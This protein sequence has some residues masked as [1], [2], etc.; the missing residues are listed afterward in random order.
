MIRWG[1]IGAGNIAHR[2]MQGMSYETDAA[3]TAVS[4]RTE[5][6]ARRFADEY[7][8]E[9]AYGGF[10]KIV[11]DP[12][13]DAVY[14][15]VPHRYHKEWVLKC[16]RAGKAVLCEKP[17]GMNADEVR[18][19]IHCAGENNVLFMEAMKTR[20][21]PLYAEIWKTICEGTIGEIA[22]VKASLC[23]LMDFEHAERKTYHTDPIGGGCLLDE[24]VYCASWIEAFL[25]KEPH[26][27]RLHAL[28]KDGVDYY[29]D[30]FLSDGEI[31]A[32]LECAFD[33]EMDRYCIISGT[34]GKI[35]IHDLHRPQKAE[36][37]GA[38]ENAYTITR[39]Y[40]HD[41]FYGEIHHFD[42]L[43]TRHQKESPVVSP[44]DSVRIA[45]ILDL[46]RQ[47]YA[48]DAKTLDLLRQEEEELRFDSFDSHD[49]F[50][51][52]SQ[53]ISLADEY[54]RGIAV[55]IT[56]EKD[57]CV[58]FQYL[59]SDKTDRNL[60]FAEGKRKASLSSGHSSFFV[61]ADHVLHGSYKNLSDDPDT[62]CLS[63]GAFPIRVNGKTEYTVSVSG[64]HEGEDHE[65]VVR[66]LYALKKKKMPD[67][68]YLLV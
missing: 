65:L 32:E 18:E 37:I 4:C 17:A 22:S 38:N 14:V 40:E 33:R 43:L 13:I 66:A 25:K 50:H 12:D 20:F 44:E 16:L 36:I 27:K 28:R 53:I 23:N 10:E 3:V 55:R 2:F 63:G 30:A 41:D 62:Y 45:E 42:E 15:A 6:K 49:A 58:V 21:V 9:K 57:A 29:N 24:G 46:I 59:D 64:L 19:M 54:D 11:E 7:H 1:I 35:I 52:G 8:V 68:P 67:F 56:R 51:L 39:P 60:F 47:G 61:Y 5:E 48:Y 34:K 26:L 31:S